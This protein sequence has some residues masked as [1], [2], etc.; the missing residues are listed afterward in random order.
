MQDDYTFVTNGPTPW[1]R[2]E[3]LVKD[4]SVTLPTDVPVGSIAYTADM[5]YMAQFDGE[6]WQEIGGSDNG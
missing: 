1:N 4:S 2:R 5:S 6:A 3:I